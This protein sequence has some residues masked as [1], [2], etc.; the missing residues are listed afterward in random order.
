VLLLVSA[1]S[2][3][4]QS[5]DRLYK[6]FKQNIGPKDSEIA[7]IDHGN[8][9]AKVLD[10]PTASE[11]F[12]FG[13]VFVKAQPSAYVRMAVDLDNLKSLPNYLAVRRFSSPPQLSDLSGFDLDADDVNDLKKC[14][15]EN[16]ETQL[17]AEQMGQFKTQID[18][19]GADPVGQ[20]NN[21]AKKM[22]LA[23]LLAYQEGGNAALGTYRDKK[24]PCSS[25]R[26][27]PRALVSLGSISV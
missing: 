17:P 6:F 26:A 19:S 22:A 1:V 9:V 14:K 21:V 13:S 2:S 8:V 15:P 3:S 24:V 23:A 10:S 18:W 12:V 7:D 27:V 11:V 25:E 5:T 20:V 16:C 4:S